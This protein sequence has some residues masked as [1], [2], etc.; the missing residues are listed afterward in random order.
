[1]KPSLPSIIKNT[2][3]LHEQD[4]LINNLK[5]GKED[6]QSIVKSLKNHFTLSLDTYTNMSLDIIWTNFKTH[7]IMTKAWVLG[8]NDPLSYKIMM[9]ER[10]IKCPFI[11]FSHMQ[12]FPLTSILGRPSHLV[13]LCNQHLRAR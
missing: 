7:L 13:K 6:Q 4:Q 1:M 5:N 10:I 9:D 8:P 3:G 11:L 12:G 2:K